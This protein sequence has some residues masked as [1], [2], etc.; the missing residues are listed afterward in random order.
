M[1]RIRGP[2]HTLHFDVSAKLFR[3]QPAV[4]QPLLVPLVLQ[5]AGRRL[6]HE[7]RD[8]RRPERAEADIRW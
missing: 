4:H 7:R 1:E 5:R 6:A 2:P 3:T 8:R